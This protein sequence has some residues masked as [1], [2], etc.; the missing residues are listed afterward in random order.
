MCSSD[1]TVTV[2][3]AVVLATDV[4]DRFLDDNELR[5]F[6]LN[7]T[8]DDEIERR[9]LRARFPQDVRDDLYAFLRRAQY[10]LAVRS[11][12]LLED[13]QHQ[14]FTGVYETFF[15]PMGGA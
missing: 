13:S 1:L 6:A 12:S 10:P 15:L 8:E 11:S 5:D 3:A 9:F 4:F 2:P 7:S 14:S